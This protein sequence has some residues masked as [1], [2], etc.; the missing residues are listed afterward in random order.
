MAKYEDI[1]TRMKESFSDQRFEL[2]KVIKDEV[3]KHEGIDVEDHIEGYD[4]EEYHTKIELKDEA[5]DVYG[6][7][8]EEILD[9]DAERV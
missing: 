5:E 3:R 8:W 9:E 7:R 4:G 2:R 1:R 6:R